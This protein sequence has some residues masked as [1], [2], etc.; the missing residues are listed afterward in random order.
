MVLS[1]ESPGTTNFKDCEN[2]NT[3]H[4]INITIVIKIFKEVVNTM[5]IWVHV[6]QDEKEKTR[7]K[8]YPFYIFVSIVF[9]NS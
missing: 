9:L 2:G 8:N 6:E 3:K 7:N 5:K 1:T 4:I